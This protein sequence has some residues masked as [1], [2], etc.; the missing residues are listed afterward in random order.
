VV[1]RG[2]LTELVAVTSVRGVY[3]QPE[4][5]QCVR[6]VCANIDGELKPVGTAFFFCITNPPIR[7]IFVVTALHVV[8]NVQK[9]SADRTTFVNSDDGKTFLRVNTK[10]GGFKIGEVAEDK[11]FKPD[12]SERSST[13]PSATGTSYRAHR[14][15]T[16]LVSMRSWQRRKM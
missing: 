4:M 11:W 2:T 12:M 8:A 15:S 16:F 5:R 14:A 1:R 3:V 13:S 7:W 6:F 10:D 9:Q